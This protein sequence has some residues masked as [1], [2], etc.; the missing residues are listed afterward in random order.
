MNLTPAGERQA[1][2]VAARLAGA[3]LS[4]VQTSPRRRARRTAEAIAGRAGVPVEATGGLDEIDFGEW[5]GRS[6]PELETEPEWHA[7]NERRGS[8]RCPGGESM[9]DAA[10]RGL[11]HATALAR[12][13]P[14]ETIALVS[15][16]DLLRGIVSRVMGLPLDKLL[17][18]DI[19]PGSISRIEIGDWGGRVCSLN[20]TA[21]LGENE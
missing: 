2:A 3:G 18:F 10:D 20:E 4:L 11:A 19:S 12:T 17:N 5:T 15:H 14:G 16:A 8:A 9:T 13:H 7:W 6:F 1:D 21:H